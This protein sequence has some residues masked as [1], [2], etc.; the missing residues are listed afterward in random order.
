MFKL[1]V[2]TIGPDN[3]VLLKA[4][5]VSGDLGKEIE[6]GSGLSADDRIIVTPPDGVTAGDVVRIAGPPT[7]TATSEQEKKSR[8]D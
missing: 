6:I 1:R 8:N 5:T 7:V 3:R 4:V 2:A